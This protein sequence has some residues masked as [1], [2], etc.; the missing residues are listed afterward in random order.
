[1]LML[2]GCGNKGVRQENH[3]PQDEILNTTS[4]V[5]WQEAYVALLWEY[6]AKPSPVEW[7]DARR[8]FILYDI[9]KDGAPELIVLY[10][11]TGFNTEAIYTFSYGDIV[12]VDGGIFIYYSTAHSPPNNRPG[13]IMAATQS[14]PDVPDI[15]SYVLMVIDDYKLINEIT[16]THAREEWWQWWN[17][18]E[19]FRESGW[20]INNKRGSESEF[21]DIYNEIFRGWD[22]SKPLFPSEITEANIQEIVFG[23]QAY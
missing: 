6:A 15:S 2:S 7:F 12:R 8:L 20:Y 23:W 5:E 16:I 10:A 9:D 14:H 21:N 17:G 11:H 4:V 22:E 19:T 1:M 18:E 3:V 13:I